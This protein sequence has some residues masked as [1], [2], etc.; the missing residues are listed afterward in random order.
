MPITNHDSYHLARRV[1]QQGARFT[2]V[3]TLAQ[4]STNQLRGQLSTLAQC[5]TNQ[6]RGQLQFQLQPTKLFKCKKRT[7][8]STFNIRNLNT[9]NQLPEL[10]FSAIELIFKLSVSKNIVSTILTSNLNIMIHDIGK[11]WTFLITCME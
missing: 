6:L 8:I 10:V 1:G 3:S 7:F 4:C 5:S 11:G 9:L 2:A